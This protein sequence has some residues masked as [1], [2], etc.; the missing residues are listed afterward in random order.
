MERKALA[1]LKKTLEKGRAVRM[2]H[3]A[4]RTTLLTYLR[5]TGGGKTVD[6]ISTA[7]NLP[8]FVVLGKLVGGVNA[9]PYFVQ[10]DTLWYA[11]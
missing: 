2:D 6:E 10:R 4:I 11:V 5:E 8:R 7:T 3:E 9:S 1:S